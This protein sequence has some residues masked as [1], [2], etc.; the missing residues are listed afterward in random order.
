MTYR[1]G[2]ASRAWTAPTGRDHASMATAI[3]FHVP[4]LGETRWRAGAAAR[5]REL[6]PLYCMRYAGPHASTGLTRHAH[7]EALA[8][9]AGSGRLVADRTYDLQ[10]G[11]TLLLPPGLGHREEARRLELLWIGLGG[12]RLHAMPATVARA[13][14]ARVVARFT[15]LWLAAQQS[16]EAD[17]VVLDALTLAAFAAFLARQRGAA[18]DGD[19]LI[20]RA[21]ALMTR[22]LAEPI[23][24]AALARE[25]KV[26]EGYFFRAFKRRTGTS[27]LAWLA[28]ARVERASAMMRA[29]DLP[30]VEIAPLVGYRDPLYFSRAFRRVTGVSPSTARA[31]MRRG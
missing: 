15:E 16:G 2:A 31:A 6:T 23:T 30:L 24:I 4:G 8:V 22:R 20:G 7:W 12:S 27:P 19:D 14:D 13:D 9:I 25:L 29:T 18:S 10:P 26:S 3:E 28:R 11:T 1:A 17:G 21:V 5:S